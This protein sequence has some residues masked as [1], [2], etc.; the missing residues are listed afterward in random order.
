MRQTVC[1]YRVC[2][3]L[4]VSEST[5]KQ[6]KPNQDN[7]GLQE[8]NILHSI[9]R[10][11]KHDSIDYDNKTPK[12]VNLHFINFQ[13]DTM[14]F[15]S[16]VNFISLTVKLGRPF[17]NVRIYINWTMCTR[18]ADRVHFFLLLVVQHLGICNSVCAF[19]QTLELFSHLAN[20][21]EQGTQNLIPQGHRHH[22]LFIFL[23]S[24]GYGKL[25]Q[26]LLLPTTTTFYCLPQGRISVIFRICCQ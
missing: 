20:Q 5:K 26:P 1:L 2:F 15:T 22:T 18:S 21:S 11:D 23:L 16:R 6:N 13:T 10:E 8:N 24:Q 12:L 3:N 4:L 7:I 25:F 19:Q 9:Y 17:E 14:C